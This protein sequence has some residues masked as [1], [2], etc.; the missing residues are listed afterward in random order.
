MDR[1]GNVPTASLPGSLTPPGS[2]IPR[3]VGAASYHL[4]VGGPGMWA[5]VPGVCCASGVCVGG[6]GDR[7]LFRDVRVLPG[8]SPGLVPWP[9]PPPTRQAATAGEGR[10]DF[11]SPQNV[12]GER[13]QGHLIC[14]NL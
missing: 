14:K 8:F 11:L 2:A 6:C 4:Q 5:S 1:L 12:L 3:A 13:V 9:V 7:T 10:H